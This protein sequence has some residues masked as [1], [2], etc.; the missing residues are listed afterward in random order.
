MD[1]VKGIKDVG[2]I[3]QEEVL[4]N[5]PNC[6]LSSGYKQTGLLT[7]VALSSNLIKAY[8][9]QNNLI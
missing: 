4:R 5:M 9:I 2:D 6:I 8:E 1:K 7:C 3:F